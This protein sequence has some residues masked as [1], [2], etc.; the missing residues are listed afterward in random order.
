MKF[1]KIKVKLRPWLCHR[2]LDNMA[3]MTSSWKLFFPRRELKTKDKYF[4]PYLGKTIKISCIILPNSS[5]QKLKL[6]KCYNFSIKGPP[7]CHRESQA[8]HTKLTIAHLYKTMFWKL[9]KSQ[10]NSF[11]KTALYT[12]IQRVTDISTKWPPWRHHF[13]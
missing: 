11:A 12:H 9:S 8:A 7:W 13:A 1:E 2:F 3:A 5:G 6:S 4:K 10:L